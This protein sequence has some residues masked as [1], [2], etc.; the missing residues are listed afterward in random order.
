MILSNNDIHRAINEGALIIDPRPKPEFPGGD[1][2]CPYQTSAVDL[3]LGEE[4]SILKKGPTA[5]DLREPGLARF[6]RDNSESVSL[7]DGRPYP[8]DPGRFILG[9]TFEKIGLPI[10]E[11]GP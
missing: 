11:E 1:V 10:R 5:M 2:E 8:L 4:L 9:K 3:R 7:V 6:P